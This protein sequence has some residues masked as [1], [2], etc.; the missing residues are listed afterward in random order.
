MSFFINR[1]RLLQAT[2][3]A[4]AAGALSSVTGFASAQPAAELKI[5]TSGG[6]WGDAIVNAFIKPFEADTGI[7]V[8]TIFQ[9]LGAAQIGMM[10]KT[11]TVSVDVTTVGQII[12][13]TLAAGDLLEKIDYSSYNKNDLDAVP[14]Y[15]RQSFG[16]ACY[17][18]S[19]N[20]F[21]NTGKAKRP[22]DWAEFWDVR[23]FPGARSLM[24]GASTP[25]P[26]EEALL[27]DGVSMNSL[28]PMDIDRIFASL[29]KIK[30]HIRKW[31][32]SGAEI[33]Q[34]MRDGVA[35]FG[36]SY[37]GRINSLIDSGAPIGIGR[38]QV[39]LTWDYWIIPKGSPN[40]QNAQKFIASTA[41]ADRQADFA[42]L[43]A[44]SPTNRNAFK[45]IPESIGRK[46]ATNPD[47]AA[48]SYPTNAKWYVEV[49]ADGLSNQDRLRRRWEDWIVL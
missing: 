25:G 17:I 34:I 10:V 2:S 18:Y 12:G 15:C 27:A 13:E 26:F 11:N 23:K 44:Q 36:Q 33:L 38:N 19:L 35:D 31:W 29:D 4:I 40:V 49:G 42:K 16:F 6:N 5:A 14:P 21:V 3:S 37:D 32:G 8:K 47:Y 20:M 22:S 1:R 48:S 43:F 30:P 45:H 39:K 28:Y 7:K 41:R 24:S 9:D 46:L